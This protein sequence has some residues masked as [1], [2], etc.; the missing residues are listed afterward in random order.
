MLLKN[1]LSNGS[2]EMNGCTI[3]SQDI[4]IHI[5]MLYTTICHGNKFH[6]DAQYIVN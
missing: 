3:K 5:C 2:P 1:R 4:P 6:F